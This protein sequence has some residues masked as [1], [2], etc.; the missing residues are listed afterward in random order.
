[1]PI[2][3]GQTLSIEESHYAAN[4]KVG[5]LPFTHLIGRVSERVALCVSMVGWGSYYFQV[6]DGFANQFSIPFAFS[7]R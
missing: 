1:M 4:A 6:A 2:D 7:V 5:R 3:A